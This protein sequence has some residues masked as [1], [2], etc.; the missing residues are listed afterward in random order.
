MVSRPV[1]RD[2]K[3]RPPSRPFVCSGCGA[4]LDWVTTRDL[5]RVHD[6]VWRCAPGKQPETFEVRCRD[7]SRLLLVYSVQ[8]APLEVLRDENGATRRA[9]VEATRERAEDDVRGRVR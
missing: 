9:V 4:S 2:M 1:V 8:G 3:A 6:V 5:R 7:C